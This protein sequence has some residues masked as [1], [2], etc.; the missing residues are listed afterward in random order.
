MARWPKERPSTWYSQY[1]RGSLVSGRP[2]LLAT[3][4]PGAQLCMAHLPPTPGHA[5]SCPFGHIT[6]PHVTAGLSQPGASPVALWPLAGLA[7]GRWS[8]RLGAAATGQGRQPSQLQ[9]HR[10][11]GHQGQEAVRG[12]RRQGQALVLKNESCLSA[13]CAFAQVPPG[14]GCGCQP[15]A[16]FCVILHGCVDRTQPSGWC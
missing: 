15:A 6:A 2:V 14:Q 4:Q 7:A 3:A 11:Q 1:K 12:G 8:L 5:C 10:S 13:Y 9:G 16:W